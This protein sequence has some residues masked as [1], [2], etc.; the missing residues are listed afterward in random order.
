MKLFSNRRLSLLFIFP[1]VMIWMLSLTMLAPAAAQNAQPAQ[2]ARTLTGWLAMTY[3]DPQPGSGIASQLRI[4]LMDDAGNTVARLAI[5]D[6]IARPYYGQRVSISGYTLD[7]GNANAQA[8]AD[9]AAPLISV[10]TITPQQAMADSSVSLTGSQPW[11]NI[12][13]K[14]SDVAATPRT[15]AYF[16]QMFTESYK[17]LDHFWRRMSYNQIDLFGSA[18]TS[19]W[20]TLPKPR[21]FYI[22]QG[23]YGA[24]LNL[25]ADDCATVADAEVNFANFV[26]VNFMFNDS[27][28]CCAWGG[29]RRMDFDGVSKFYRTTWL[30]PWGQRHDTIGHEMGHGF[31]MPHS[32]GPANNPP[33]ELDVYV[34]HWDVMSAAGGACRVRDDANTYC[35]SQ[36]T[37]AYQRTVPGWI[38]PYRLHVVPSNSIDE[39]TLDRLILPQTDDTPLMVRIPINNSPTHF[40]TVEVRD[41]NEYDQNIPNRAVVIHDV[42]TM[43]TGNAGH[44]YVVDSDGNNNVNDAGAIW[45]V[46]EVFYDPAS[47]I[48]IEVLSETGGRYTLRVNNNASLIAGTV[49]EADGT[50]PIAGAQVAALEAD[51]SSTADSAT[52]DANGQYTLTVAP[53]SYRLVAK[54]TGRAAEFY[55]GAALAD[56]AQ[57]VTAGV[58]ATLSGINFQLDAGGTISGVVTGGG[59]VPL[60]AMAVGIENTTLTTCTGFDGAYTLTNVPLGAPLV[61]FSGG[62]PCDG[63]DFDYSVEWWQEAS[64]REEADPI[65]LTQDMPNLTDI[66]FTLR[67][68]AMV[69]GRVT[70]AEGGKPI[71]AAVVCAYPDTATTFDQS[72]VDT[73]ALTEFDGFYTLDLPVGVYRLRA[74]EPGRVRL[75]YDHSPTYQGATLLSVGA[76]DVLTDKDFVLPVA[77]EVSGTVYDVDGVTPLPGITLTDQHNGYVGCSRSDGSYMLT[78]PVGTHI[79][80]ASSG[81]C[82]PLASFVTQY[83][84][85]SLTP[86]NATPITI[87]A[88]GESI[89]DVNFINLESAD[90]LLTNG[91]FEQSGQSAKLPASWVGVNLMNDGRVCDQGAVKSRA[92]NGSCA[93]Q[94]TGNAGVVSSLV[95]T[96]RPQ[97]QPNQWLHLSAWVQGKNVS[98]AKIR[99]VIKYTGGRT[100]TLVLD[101][102]ALNAG[103]YP[104]QQLSAERRL[105]WPVKRIKVILRNAS[106]KGRLRIDEISL[107]ILPQRTMGR[108]LVPLPAAPDDLRGS[109]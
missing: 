47:N 16:T 58:S 96:V 28:D 83:Y 76:D 91:G 42:D 71:P 95:Q 55:N 52:T 56:Q 25:L 51:T 107:R 45:I 46:G 23:T 60:Y 8:G 6:S 36:G 33:V 34:S 30:P 50:T 93:F 105:K 29:G 44:A 49:Y 88:P 80:K 19:Q 11:V 68:S 70:M 41:L 65:T 3:G 81:P 75:F 79:I 22:D 69:V 12:L 48:S 54:A 15:P 43:R 27:L 102:A 63:G 14:F 62:F 18:T 13:C 73:C 77:G 74:H 61:I 40:Y 99:A 57:I 86:E 89:T 1:A 5:S 87:S 53:G 104:Y 64:W 103:T 100:Q 21:S 66:H 32:T 39:V 20:Y 109:N 9:T 38:P 7:T 90:E 59:S 67:K 31:G 84:E 101:P 24:N 85:N 78:L 17:G 94:L 37:S 26:G 97:T 92:R 82:D 2:T 108:D 10:L 98:G 35:L 4:T 72:D 106:G